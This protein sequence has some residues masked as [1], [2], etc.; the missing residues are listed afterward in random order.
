MTPLSLRRTANRRKRLPAHTERKYARGSAPAADK[1]IGPFRVLAPP[2]FFTGY[3]NRFFDRKMRSPKKLRSK[4]LFRWH[5]ALAGEGLEGVVTNTRRT[6]MNTKTEQPIKTEI[7]GLYTIPEGLSA[8]EFYAYLDSIAA[9]QVQPD[10]SATLHTFA[11]HD[12]VS[13]S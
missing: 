2:T 3:R 1:A 12:E 7:I 9:G 10:M 4:T 6:M 11:T 13:H 8:E 5:P